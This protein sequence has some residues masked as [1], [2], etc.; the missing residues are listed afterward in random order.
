MGEA[1]VQ[2]V[3]PAA[4]LTLYDYER[5]P[6]DGRRHEVIDGV[7]V[8]S[9]PPV[10]RH[11]RVLRRL[12]KAV[13]VA[14]EAQN[15]GS[16]VFFAPA[17]VILSP[18][19]IVE[20]DLFYVSAARSAILESRYVHGA[21]D[22]VVEVLSPSTRRTDET[23]KKARYELFGAFELWIV[24]PDADVIRLYRRERVGGGFG[25]VIELSAERDD[26]ITTPLL[27][28]LS[29]GLADLFAR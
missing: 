16:E 12:F 10:L 1:N 4:K 13:D 27:P 24:D 23:L 21:P 26:M 19:D 2:T 3:T 5:F 9:P 25:Q 6:E 20:P 11:Q 28:A 18:H 22:L 17:G 7:E 14:A 8:V 29:L 15:D